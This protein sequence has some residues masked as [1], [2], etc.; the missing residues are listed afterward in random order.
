MLSSFTQQHQY[1]TQNRMEH[2]FKTLP[3]HSRR[4]RSLTGSAVCPN[5]TP[6]ATD[7]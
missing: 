1:S 6:L 7:C 2:R 3:Y 5:V 4:R